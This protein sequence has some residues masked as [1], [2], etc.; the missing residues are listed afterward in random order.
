[1]DSHKISQYRTRFH[2]GWDEYHC[3]RDS[4]HDSIELQEDGFLSY[5]LVLGVHEKQAYN[6]TDV[7]DGYVMKILIV[8][9]SS[10][11]E[12]TTADEETDTC[13]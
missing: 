9:A 5:P 3:L 12:N 2:L 4:K 13:K 8:V 7:T 1:M 6:Y 11:N 10:K